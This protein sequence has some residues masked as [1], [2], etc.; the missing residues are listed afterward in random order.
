MSQRTLGDQLSLFHFDI[1][2]PSDFTYITNT[3]VLITVAVAFFFFCFSLLGNTVEPRLYTHTDTHRY[4]SL[5]TGEMHRRHTAPAAPLPPAGPS[6]SRASLDKTR[7]SPQ[8]NAARVRTL[9]Q[10]KGPARLSLASQTFVPWS[11]TLRSSQPMYVSVPGFGTTRRSP[12]KTAAPRHLPEIRPRAVSA[13]AVI[14]FTQTTPLPLPPATAAAR[15]LVRQKSS[16]MA[17]RTLLDVEGVSTSAVAAMEEGGLST[18]LVEVSASSFEASQRHRHRPLHFLLDADTRDEVAASTAYTSPNAVIFAAYDTLRLLLVPLWWRYRYHKLLAR[19]TATVAKFVLA[20]VHGRRCRQRQRA[21]DAI[22]YVLRSPRT[23][24]LCAARQLQIRV[25]RIQRAYRLHRRCV[26]AVVELNCRKVRR[27]VEKTYWTAVV[28]RREMELAAQKPPTS[29]V[30]KAIQEVLEA[31]RDVHTRFGTVRCPSLV[32]SV[33][34][35]P[36]ANS[37]AAAAAAS[38]SI[39]TSYEL[40]VYNYYMI[41]RLPESMLRFEI[42]SAVF[43]HTR[44]SAERACLLDDLCTPKHPK[45]SG[46]DEKTSRASAAGGGLALKSPNATT[47]KTRSV[48]RLPRFF[49]ESVYTSI[50][51]NTCYMTSLMRDDA[52]LR[53]HLKPHASLLEPY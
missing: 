3:A 18:S 10:P 49:S 5:W 30:A 13:A 37:K 42:A 40:D 52:M 26:Q 33:A 27:D 44:R 48:A 23:Q 20:K 25:V 36:A 8:H 53:A 46:V 38:A 41:G 2:L 50:L 15:G 4:K 16:A 24:L 31:K 1:C 47:P 51:N 35:T 28:S 12:S 39:P 21:A 19:A 45:R 43:A 22:F 34:S 9:S 7:R 29:A 14:V 6:T 32:S 11:Q 17:P